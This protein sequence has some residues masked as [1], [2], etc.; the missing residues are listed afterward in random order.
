MNYIFDRGIMRWFDHLFEKHTNT[1]SIDNFICNMYDRARP[2]DK[3]DILPLATK[4]YK[5]DSVISLAKKESSFWTISFL[6]SSKYVY[7]LRENVHPYFGHY[8]YENIS[9]YN[10][11]DVY[12]FVNKYL[13]DILN[14]MVDYIYYPEED[15][16]YIDYRDEFIN[17]CSDMDYG[18]RVLVTED[19]Y[20]YIISEDQLNFIDKSERFNL[21]LRFDSRGG[22]ELM[23]AI[24]D[25]SRSILLKTR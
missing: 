23:D 17:T 11:D 9:V 14:Y 18:E 2:V 4:K 21:E 24:L 22:Q 5:D 13:L 10:N 7:E 12:S 1:F 3:S 20:M 25:L 15:D 16:Y 19:I 8:I 6:L